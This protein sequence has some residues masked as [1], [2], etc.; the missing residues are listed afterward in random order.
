MLFCDFVEKPDFSA[1]MEKS[2]NPIGANKHEQKH[3]N[4]GSE[5]GFERCFCGK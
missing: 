1:I 2:T 3:K 5:R 4:A